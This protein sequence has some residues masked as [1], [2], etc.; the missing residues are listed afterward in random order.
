VAVT[1]WLG[2]YVANLTDLT[3]ADPALYEDHRRADDLAVSTH[4]AEV[5]IQGAE[6]RLVRTTPSS[7]GGL[8][9]FAINYPSWAS[10]L[11]WSA[12]VSE[13]PQCPIP[14]SSPRLGSRSP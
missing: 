12:G 14:R 4:G 5:G 10:R 11:P 8:P 13:A 7:H 9:M 1:V 2:F 6:A 3:S